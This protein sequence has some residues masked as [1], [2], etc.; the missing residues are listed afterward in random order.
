MSN[1]SAPS[2]GTGVSVVTQDKPDFYDPEEG[3]SAG[4]AFCAWR[5]NQIL[6]GEYPC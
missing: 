2:V 3:K 1:L 4:F 6:K 5:M